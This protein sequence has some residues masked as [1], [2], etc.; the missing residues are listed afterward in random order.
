MKSPNTKDI[1]T[2][3]AGEKQSGQDFFFPKNKLGHPITI[4]AK[5]QSDADDKLKALE[6]GNGE[7][8]ESLQDNL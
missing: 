4:R 5:S 3:E 8:G 7:K 6:E 2:K 1:N